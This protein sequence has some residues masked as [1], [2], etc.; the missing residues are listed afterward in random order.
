[1]SSPPAPVELIVDE[2]MERTLT[3]LA[4]RWSDL[5]TPATVARRAVFAG[6]V[7]E[8]IVRDYALSENASEALAKHAL[9]RRAWKDFKLP[10]DVLTAVNHFFATQEREM[11]RTRQ[12]ALLLANTADGAPV[13]QTIVDSIEVLD[14][15]FASSF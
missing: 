14:D 13:A 4:S 1:M 5:S 12:R 8:A 3:W 11:R 10:H 7:L 6:A 2:P 9:I 15:P